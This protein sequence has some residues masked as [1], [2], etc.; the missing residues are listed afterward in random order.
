MLSERKK[1]KKKKRKGEKEEKKERERRVCEK[2]GRGETEGKGSRQRTFN[3]KFSNK[4]FYCEDS[5]PSRLNKTFFSPPCTN[6]SP[7]N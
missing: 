1:K 5:G 4:C 3:K 7:F 6:I 2:K